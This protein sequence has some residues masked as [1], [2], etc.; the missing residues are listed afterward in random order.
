MKYAVLFDTN[1]L[2]LNGFSE[3]DF[4]VEKKF[5]KSGT[6]TGDYYSEAE[7]SECSFCFLL[8][9]LLLKAFYPFP[10][11][12]LRVFNLEEVTLIFYSAPPLKKSEVQ[13]R[14]WKYI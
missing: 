1:D 12:P 2:W 7:I 6:V 5:G 3:L 8:I 10:V 13:I 9:I 14:I 11:N 4:A